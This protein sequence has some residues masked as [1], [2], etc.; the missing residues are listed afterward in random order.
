VGVT[1]HLPNGNV[2]QPFGDNPKGTVLF[3]PDEHFALIQSR[4]ELPQIASNDRNKATAEEA[5]AIVAGSI[6]Y[7]GTYSV[8]EAAKSLSIVIEGSTFANLLGTP[9][10]KVINSLS[11]NELKF[12]NP[13]TPSGMTLETIWK[14][15]SSR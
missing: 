12:A 15:A 6:A 13:R 14:R 7:Y 2:A 8:N 5:K 3:T 4:S 9:A 10:Q 11:G 1:A